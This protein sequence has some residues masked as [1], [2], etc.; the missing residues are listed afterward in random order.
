MLYSIIQ[1]ICSQVVVDSGVIPV[2]VPL[3]AHPDNRV[4][5]RV[6]SYPP[7]SFCSFLPPLYF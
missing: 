6:T 1:Y 5:V 4:V 7:L 3:L 2:L